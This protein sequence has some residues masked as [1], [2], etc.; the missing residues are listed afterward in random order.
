MIG[1]ESETQQPKNATSIDVEG[2]REIVISRTFGG[3]ARIVFEV[4]TKAEH[5]SRWFAPKSLGVEMV[6]CHAD[7]RI[8]GKYRYVIRTRGQEIA[9]S[10][11]YTEITPPTRL[12]YTH[13][14]EPMAEAGH[15]VVTVSFEERNGKT[16]VVS[17]ELYPSAE[18]RAAALGS[19]MAKGI[20]DTMDQLDAIVVS[21]S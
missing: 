18:I 4:W 19:G 13:V 6:S 1:R 5:V 7:V 15:V 16:R 10:G 20:Y 3:P 21:M 12:V 2:E 11:E 8:G 14:Y 17:R 9:F